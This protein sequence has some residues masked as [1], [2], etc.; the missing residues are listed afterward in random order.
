MKGRVSDCTG[1][2]AGLILTLSLTSGNFVPGVYVSPDRTALVLSGLAIALVAGVFEE[3]GWTGFAVATL[4]RRY[5]VFQTGLAVGVP[6]AA[7]H[8]LVA[9]WAVGP[10]PDTLSLAS[11]LLDPLLFLVGF[12]VLMVWVYDRTESILVAMMMHASL[13]A[14]ALIL[15][16]P[17]LRG[18]RF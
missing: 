16:A 2:D 12:R 18:R 14:S 1:C 13:T 5:G 6:W 11:Y 15:G 4:R 17:A 7:W 8:W 9:V 10:L 3:L